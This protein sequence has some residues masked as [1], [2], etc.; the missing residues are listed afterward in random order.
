MLVN[1]DSTSGT[2]SFSNFVFHFSTSP[3]ELAL[4][5][6]MENGSI[7]RLLLILFINI[8]SSL[9]YLGFLIFHSW[10]TFFF[11]KIMFWYFDFLTFQYEFMSIITYGG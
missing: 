8:V 2:F 3:T 5:N 6:N 4:R 9:Y 1:D 7:D 11:G 10:I